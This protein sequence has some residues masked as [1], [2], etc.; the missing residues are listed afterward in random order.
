MK[1]PSLLSGRGTRNHCAREDE[2][3]V[4]RE[5]AGCKFQDARLSERFRKLLERIGS[6]IGQA[7]PFACQDWANTKAAYRFFSN[8]RVDE[9]AILSGHFEATHDRFAATDG[10]V[11]VLHD[12]TEFSFKREKPELI[13]ST[14]KVGRKD[15]KGRITSHT[16][17]GILMHSS[18]VVTTE[19]LPLGLAAIKF[20]TR[21]KFKGCNALKKK[22]N[23]TRVPI[24]EKESVRWLTNLRQ[25]TTL[26]DAPERCVHVT[27]REGDIYELFCEAQEAN[28]HFLI[29]TYAD[30]LAGDGE[31]TVA[32]EMDEVRVKGLHRVEVRDR[33]GD[34]DEAI[35]EI[36]YR[37]IKVL[38]PIGKQKRYSP[39]TLT[40]IYAQERGTP[41][42]RDRIEWKL[43]TDL[44][45][46]SRKDAIEKINWYAMRWKIE[47][48]HKILKSGCRA[49][50]SQLRTAERLVNLISVFCILSWRVFWL[51]MLNRTDPDAS[52]DL[53]LTQYEISLLDKLVAEKNEGRSA[54]KT[55]SHYLIKIARLGGYLARANDG[56]PGNTVIWRGLSRLISIEFAV[57]SG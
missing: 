50:E 31:H 13:G 40:V 35:L 37:R 28:T 19:G 52:P 54:I 26:L 38:P 44:P 9:E 47:T 14:R 10:Y 43:V 5:V 7:I 57:A 30:R 4:D 27:D 11:L 21:K 18:L 41:K 20:W 17:C 34:V 51:T 12:T 15:K 49:E 53:A 36:R 48:F 8:D 3:W 23:P 1:L 56:P 32:D 29:R 2:S 39:L 16:V 24:E 33:N 46:Q 22:I 6:A 55:I 45:V 25:S 42:N